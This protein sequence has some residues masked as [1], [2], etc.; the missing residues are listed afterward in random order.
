MPSALVGAEVLRKEALNCGPCS[1]LFIQ[2]PLSVTQSPAL[3]SA[4]W[5]TT[6]TRSR[7]ASGLDAQLAEAVLGVLEGD[8]LDR[9]RQHLGGMAA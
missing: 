6:V 8:A 5:P 9:S 2:V 1:R 7:L 3:I 4:E